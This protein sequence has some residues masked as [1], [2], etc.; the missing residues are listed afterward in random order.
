MLIEHIEDTH[1][2][3]IYRIK[4]ERSNPLNFHTYISFIN[5]MN[6]VNAIHILLRSQFVDILDYLRPTDMNNRFDF[7]QIKLYFVV[8]WQ[9]CLKRI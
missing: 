2:N 3:Y 8:K 4:R 7:G 6:D 1:S 5:Q 9:T